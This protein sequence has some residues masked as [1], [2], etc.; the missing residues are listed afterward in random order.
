MTPLSPATTTSSAAFTA[1]RVRRLGVPPDTRDI[2]VL[3]QLDGIQD[4]VT[5][6]SLMHAGSALW[7]AWRKHPEFQQHDLMLGLDAGGILPTVAMAL[8]VG[9]PYRLAWKLDLDLPAKRVF[10]EP[11]AR[12]TE[13]FVYGDLAGQ[14]ILMVDDE[15]T[16]GNTLAN[17]AA[18][19]RSGG[20]DIIG[21]AVLVEDLSG[22]G[23]HVLADQGVPLCALTSL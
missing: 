8:A 23:R 1:S 6:E 4:A 22:E 5:P 7:D 19:L 14:R 16:T 18:A 3:H 17:L 13:V 2:R 11:H 10:H 12:R 9:T 15:I 20:A 21:A